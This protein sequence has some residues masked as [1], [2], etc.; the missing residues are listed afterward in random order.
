[1]KRTQIHYFAK[2]H[3]GQHEDWW[4]L[5]EADDG[6]HH[7]EH[8]WDHVSVGSGNKSEGTTRHSIEYALKNAPTK[9]VAK[10]KELLGLS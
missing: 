3:L 2:G 7:V 5:V 9:A 10:L 1:M 6:T 4:Y 8:E